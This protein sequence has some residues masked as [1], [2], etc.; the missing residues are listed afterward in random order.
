VKDKDQTDLIIWIDI[1]Q[2][3]GEMLRI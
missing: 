2:L 1:R 3:L